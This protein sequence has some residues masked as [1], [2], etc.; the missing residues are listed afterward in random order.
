[1]SNNSFKSEL[2]KIQQQKINY[3]CEFIHNNSLSQAEYYLNKANWDENV[4]I[5]LYYNKPDYQ[6]NHKQNINNYNK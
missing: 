3:F 4:A 6:N 5:E 1:M 2:Q